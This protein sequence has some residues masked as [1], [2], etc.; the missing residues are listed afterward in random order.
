V[1]RVLPVAHLSREREHLVARNHG[2]LIGNR[3]ARLDDADRPLCEGLFNL[4]GK[5][6]GMAIF[7]CLCHDEAP[8]N[9][10]T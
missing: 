2:S 7:R 8:R 5:A 9:S 10:P 3:V 1:A 4:R 6:K